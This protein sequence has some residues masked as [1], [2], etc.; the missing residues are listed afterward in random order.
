V[1]AAGPALNRGG[2]SI[3]DRFV[4]DRGRF[5]AGPHAASPIFGAH[6]SHTSL[7]H[8][9]EHSTASTAC[10]WFHTVTNMPARSAEEIFFTN[11]EGNAASLDDVIADGLDGA[12][13]ERVPDLLEL[14]N[15]GTPFHRL[16]ACI[17]LTSWGHPDGFSTI[18]RWAREPTT[19][20]WATAPVTRDRISAADDAF[21][22]LAD[23]LKTSYWNDETPK[24][25]RMQQEAAGALLDIYP[26]QYFGRTLALAL[27]RDP[28]WRGPRRQDVIDALDRS[29][30]VLQSGTKRDFDLPFQ[31]ASLLMVV[32]PADD[33]D[34]A[35]VA[36][37]L[38]S[39]FPEH[40][41]VLREVAAAL[42]SAAGAA[43]LGVLRRLQQH[44]SVSVA[45][46]AANALT[47]RQLQVDAP[48]HEDS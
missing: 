24:L 42:G 8:V 19:V 10:T 32:A 33:H 14:L 20:P 11:G 7:A 15:I 43:T 36:E 21:A 34:A 27:R 41:R 5:G 26:D 1:C 16:I 6:M 2:R 37:R 35:K 9:A 46:E 3:T 4:L 17:V 29:L 38:I 39:Q 31:I 18:A 12:Y 13:R 40:D 45:A 48:A 44:R 47:L 23:A 25:R 28:I 30:P 22:S